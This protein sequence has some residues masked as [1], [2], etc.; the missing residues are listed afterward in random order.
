M[1]LVAE[2]EQVAVVAV[3]DLE[4]FGR[5]GLPLNGARGL[6][7][8][9]AAAA[10]AAVMPVVA[11]IAA[12]VARAVP[13]GYRVGPTSTTQQQQRPRSTSSSPS[14]AG[15]RYPARHCQ[16]SCVSPGVGWLSGIGCFDRKRRPPEGST[17][18]LF[19]SPCAQKRRID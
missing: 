19:E 6:A 14:G 2:R 4:S 9:L 1:L 3:E 10:A 17:C 7:M 11:A 13:L 12:V 8:Y 16:S 15:Q 18:E 5:S